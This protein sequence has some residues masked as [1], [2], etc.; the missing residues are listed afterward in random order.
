MKI[1]TTHLQT[2]STLAG[3]SFLSAYT[4]IRGVA[5]GEIKGPNSDNS[6][7]LKDARKGGEAKVGK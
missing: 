1:E 5:E 3:G 2:D 7:T 6:N 4:S